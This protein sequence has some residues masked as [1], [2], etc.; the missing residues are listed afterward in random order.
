MKIIG[1]TGGIASGKS[2]VARLLRQWG[3]PVVDA[4]QLARAIV[5]PGQPAFLDIVDFFGADVLQSDGHLDRKALGALVFGSPE[6]R[7]KLNEFTH[8]RVAQLAQE[9]L[10]ECRE[11]G[12]TRLVYEVPLLFE[13]GLDKS[14]DASLLVA[15]SAEVQL[16][17]LMQRDQSSAD[18]ARQRIASQMPL[19][20][21]LQRAD[22]TLWNNDSPQQLEQALSLLWSQLCEDLSLSS[23]EN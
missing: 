8:P 6:N 1:L 12:V 22:Y 16:Q 15:V 23:T 21:K 20:D 14:V 11:Q 2:T 19:E 4:D 13:V 3:H 5:E 18:A 9:T 17:R 7:Q 10:Q